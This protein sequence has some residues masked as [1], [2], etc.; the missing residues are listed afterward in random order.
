MPFRV[1]TIKHK[2]RRKTR[3]FFSFFFSLK[4]LRQMRLSA[5][6]DGFFLISSRQPVQPYTR[7]FPLRFSVR[8]HTRGRTSHM[9]TYIISHT[10]NEMTQRKEN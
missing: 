7:Q 5:W 9:I 8:L 3:L 4:F 10:I 1:R 6:P 2:I